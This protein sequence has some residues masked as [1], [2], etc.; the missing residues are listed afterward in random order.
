MLWGWEPRTFYEYDDDGR[1]VSSWTESPWD[2]TE[3]DLL[4]AEN[5]VTRL[6]GRNGE[7]LPDATSPNADPT[8]YSG[9]RYVRRGPFTNWSEKER[10]DGLDAH[11]KS[12]GENA[13][14]NGVYFTVERL[15]Y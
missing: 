13:N 4:I 2:E 1:L 10:L 3:R 5:I 11:A 12:L 14:M 8:A 9:Y 6:T 15:D 7:W